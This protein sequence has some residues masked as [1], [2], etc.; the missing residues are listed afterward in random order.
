MLI[1]ITLINS[2]RDNMEKTFEELV[3]D[4][5]Y[6]ITN[7]FRKDDIL[8]LLQQVRE[9]TIEECANIESDSCSSVETQRRINELPTDRITTEK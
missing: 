1:L 5:H 8:Q 7:S 6:D 2:Y 3:N 4:I 9:A